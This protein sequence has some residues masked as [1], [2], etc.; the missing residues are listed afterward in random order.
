MTID[1]TYLC[2]SLLRKF[3]HR[4]GDGRK[5]AGA[6][7]D[8][9]GKIDEL[10]KMAHVRALMEGQPTPA[11]QRADFGDRKGRLHS[12]RRYG[13]CFVCGDPASCRHH[14][15][16]LQHGGINH[17]LNLVSLCD[18]CHAEIHPWLR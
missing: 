14:I 10:V 16:Q 13:A 11:A 1:Y 3:W 17:R 5:N 6:Q 15:I 9:A 8:R 4:V 7:M 2:R 18:P 12:F